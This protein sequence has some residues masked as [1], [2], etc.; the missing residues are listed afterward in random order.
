MKFLN[1]KDVNCAFAGLGL[2]ALAGYK[3]QIALIGGPFK[4]SLEYPPSFSASA[5][6]VSA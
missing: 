2:S 6:S 4:H 1:Q 3:G 5:M